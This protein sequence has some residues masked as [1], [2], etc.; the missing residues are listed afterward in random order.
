MISC[1]VR[2]T[3]AWVTRRCANTI[4]DACVAGMYPGMSESQI[5]ETI[6][7]TELRETCRYVDIS[8]TSDV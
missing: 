6:A 4:F 1:D 8:A 7:N 5:M 3:G 2:S